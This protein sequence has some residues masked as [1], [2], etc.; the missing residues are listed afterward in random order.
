MFGIKV[1]KISPSQSSNLK[2]WECN[3]SYGKLASSL[4]I[5]QDQ[6]EAYRDIPSSIRPTFLFVFLFSEPVSACHNQIAICSR[7]I[8]IHARSLCSYN[9]LR[10]VSCSSRH[11]TGQTRDSKKLSFNWSS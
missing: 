10:K 9:A 2:L 7:A 8:V 11:E 6:G 4:S 5:F 1:R 3:C